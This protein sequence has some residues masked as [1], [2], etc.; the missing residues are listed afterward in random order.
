[1][2]GAGGLSGRPGGLFRGRNLG[3]ILIIPVMNPVELLLEVLRA[4]LPSVFFDSKL[5]IFQNSGL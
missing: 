4:D 2:C 3:L 5:K 1:M